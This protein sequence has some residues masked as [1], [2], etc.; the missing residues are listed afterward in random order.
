MHRAG[1]TAAALH[2]LQSRRGS[3]PRSHPLNTIFKAPRGRFTVKACLYLSSQGLRGH[4]LAGLAGGARPPLDCSVQALNRPPSD[5][6]SVRQSM[7]STISVLAA[8]ADSCRSLSLA[9]ASSGTLTA[10][11]PI[12]STP[13]QAGWPCHL[14][15]IPFLAGGF[16]PVKI[17]FYVVA[18]HNYWGSGPPC[19]GKR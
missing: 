16:G 17:Q 8:P 12:F 2:L 4:V 5:R 15:C 3:F 10:C 7:C 13:Q 6:H 18:A 19:E 9:A 14:C 1:A 11:C